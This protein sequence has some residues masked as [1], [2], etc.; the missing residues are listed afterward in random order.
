MEGVESVENKN[1]RWREWRVWRTRIR[2]G[3]SGGCGE[4]ELEMEGERKGRKS[5][6]PVTIP[7][8]WHTLQQCIPLT[9]PGR[10]G[11]VHRR[12]QCGPCRGHS[13]T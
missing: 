11:L 13:S 6:K 8:T 2:D 1:K 7:Q 4:Q 12:S 10:Q 9:F 3:G 5:Q